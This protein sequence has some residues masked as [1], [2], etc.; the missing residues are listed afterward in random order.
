[1]TYGP[2]RKKRLRHVSKAT[3]RWH[4]S[5]SHSVRRMMTVAWEMDLI[6][7]FFGGEPR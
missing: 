2:K 1:M 6:D 5:W 4:R 7:N 3:R